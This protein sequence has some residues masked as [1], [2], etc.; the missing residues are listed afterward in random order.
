MKTRLAFFAVGLLAAAIA[1]ADSYANKEPFSQTNPF[2]PTGTLSLENVNGNVEIRTW[3][4]N[5]ILIQGEKSAKTEEELKAIDLK[6]DVSESHA[7]IK[8]RLP[9]R[10]G[11]WFS[12][13]TI[14][15]AVQFTITLPATAS[16]DRIETV[17][18][19][20]KL[21]G[22]RG[23]AHI[24][25]VNGSVRATNLGG[26]TTFETV[27]G[28]IDADFTAVAA[29]QTCSFETVNGSVHMV[30]PKDAG[31]A[32]RTSVVNGHVDCDFPLT[33]TKSSGRRNLSGNI[34]D[35][36]ASLSAET[37]NGSIHIS[38]RE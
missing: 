6:I 4:K 34:G 16:L 32:L 29:G 18:A 25:T 36:R 9:K 2:S 31:V 28:R 30:L 20:V 11:G 5:E 7:A 27:N 1:R 24:E 17:N 23:K 3:D 14:R 37:V 10:S 22:T 38:R 19:S 13:N 15:A 12:G 35:G 26:S 21:E 33:L 8:V